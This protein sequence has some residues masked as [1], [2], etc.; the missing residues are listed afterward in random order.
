MDLRVRRIDRF[1]S[2][3]FELTDTD[4]STLARK[5]RRTRG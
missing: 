1:T 5:R 3:P 4:P 2:N